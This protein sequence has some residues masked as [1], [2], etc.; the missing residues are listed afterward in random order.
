MTAETAEAALALVFKSPSPSIKIEFQ[1][2]EPMLNFDRIIHIVSRAEEINLSEKR[3]LQFVIATNLAVVTDEIL[4]FCKEHSIL[5]STSLDGPKD[6]HNKNRPRPGHDSYERAIA[7]I[8]KARQVLGHDRVS[9]LMT[10]TL[11]SLGRAKD[12]IDEYIRL[13]FN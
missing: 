9:A 2:G 7:G 3:D 1:G 12:I 5:I 8:E 10:T 13:E 4:A 6:L 11:G